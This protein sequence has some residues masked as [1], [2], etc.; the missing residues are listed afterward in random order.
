MSRGGVFLNDWLTSWHAIYQDAEKKWPLMTQIDQKKY[1]CYLEETAG[2]LIDQWTALDELLN[3]LRAD[4]AQLHSLL[5]YHSLGTTY[6]Q[7]E[8]FAQAADQLILEKATG[9]QE[10][11]RYLYLGF[12]Y[13]FSNQ[14]QKAK[15]KYLYLI[16]ISQNTYIKHFAF[17]GLGCVQTRL[18]C[19]EDAIES[20]ESA[21]RLTTTSDVVYNLGICYFSIEAF[22][23]A[24]LYFTDYLRHIPEDG[25]ALFLLG[26][27]QW[28]EGAREAAW[29]SWLTS[30][31]LLDSAYALLA[32]AYVCEWHGHHQAAIH[33]YRRIQT[34]E[35]DQANILHGIAWNY[36]LLEDKTNALT[37]FREALRIEPMNTDIQKSLFWL[38]EN[39]PELGTELFVSL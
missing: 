4:Q 2:E 34:K 14:L 7:L 1:L 12:A 5:H 21:N 29:T 24:K 3:H 20:F 16:Q 10:E 26:C 19:M 39:W 9:E 11:I 30:V 6:Y 27:C 17:V 18:D 23:L 35:H 8:M 28:Q 37:A 22:H 33:C 13:L 25:E 38:N 32:L 36:A 31:N 15:E